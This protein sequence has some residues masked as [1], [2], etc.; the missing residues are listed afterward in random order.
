MK[1]PD[2]I[3]AVFLGRPNRFVAMVRFE[4][5]ERA[6]AYVPTT[7]RLMNALQPGC[8]VWLAGTNDPHR[9]TKFTLL[10]TELANGGYCAVQAI[11]ANHLFAKAVTAG[12][13]PGFNYHQIEEEVPFGNS[14]LDF[15]LT[16]DGE[17]CW[18][19]VK[20]VTYAAGGVCKFP[21]APT[22]RGRKHL[23]ELAK[24]AEL[25][26]RARVVFIAPRED[27]QAFTPFKEI[28]PEFTAVLSDVHQQGV[29]VHAYRCDVNLESIS[30]SSEIDTKL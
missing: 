11:Q 15:R 8:R 3:P 26:D 2:L 10:L 1:F 20:S 17:H 21:D 25:G 22:G 23:R 14:R 16:R 30:I 29:E 28:D 7:G 13:L 12:K 24:L 6:K 5:G 18:V 4:N 19:E 9:R 27:T